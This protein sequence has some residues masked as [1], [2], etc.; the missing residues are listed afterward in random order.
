MDRIQDLIDV[1]ESK[2]FELSDFE[3]PADMDEGWSEVTREWPQELLEDAD[4]TYDNNTWYLR[5]YLYDNLNSEDAYKKNA[6]RGAAIH[7]LLHTA[8]RT[9]EGETVRYTTYK[10][11][12]ANGGEHLEG[13]VHL[14][15]EEATAELMSIYIMV[16][17]FEVKDYW[18]NYKISYEPAV[19][20][21]AEWALTTLPSNPIRLLVSMFSSNSTYFLSKHVKEIEKRHG[22]TSAKD[23]VSHAEWIEDFIYGFEPEDKYGPGTMITF[24]AT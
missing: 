4:G 22:N 18:K 15:F 2:Y 14:Y 19:Y 8:L 24:R 5:P 10:D 9:T 23:I 13:R 17:D 11:I 16:K 1:I 3:V 21:L 6:A 12:R 20:A 7:E